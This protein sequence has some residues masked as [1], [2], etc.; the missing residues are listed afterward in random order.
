M[1]R[2]SR[3]ELIGLIK[4]H[5]LNDCKALFLVR[6]DAGQLKEG[7]VEYRYPVVDQK[8]NVSIARFVGLP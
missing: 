4:A 1:T 6:L 7:E 2:S 5:E 8:G 3:D